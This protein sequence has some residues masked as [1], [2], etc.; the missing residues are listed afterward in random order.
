MIG[1]MNSMRPFAKKQSH[2]QVAD[3]ERLAT[4]SQAHRWTGPRRRGGYVP[5]PEDVSNH[6]QRLSFLPISQPAHPG[7]FTTPPRGVCA[8][9]QLILACTVTFSFGSGFDETERGTFI[10]LQA[11]FNPTLILLSCSSSSTSTQPSRLP[12]TSEEPFSF[13]RS[14]RASYHEAFHFYFTF[15]LL[16]S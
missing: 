7:L 3:A 13:L 12:P 16:S 1:L 8:C 11:L 9:H 10:S 14:A 6:K 2:A 4:E 5:G 15:T